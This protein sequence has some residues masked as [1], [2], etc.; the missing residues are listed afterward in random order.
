M[1]K[2]MSPRWAAPGTA[3]TNM[4]F[5]IFSRALLSFD[6]GLASAGGIFAI[7]IANIVA[8]FFARDLQG[9]PD[10][11]AVAVALRALQGALS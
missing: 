6:V 4:P 5:Y 3:T 8:F 2:S 7:L 11:G 9:N 1:R 10:P